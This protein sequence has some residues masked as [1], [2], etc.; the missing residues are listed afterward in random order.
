MFTKIEISHRTIIFTIALLGAIWLILQILDILYFMFIAF[1]IMSTLRPLVDWLSMRRIPRLL[2]ILIIYCVI[3]GFVGVSLLGTVPALVVQS[4]R[5]MQNLPAFTARIFPYWTIDMNAISQQIAP[6]GEN[7]VKVT[8]GIFSNI[9]TTFAVLI[10]SFYFLLEYKQSEKYLG[11][12][13][14]SHRAAD[15]MA[16]IRR[17]EMRLGA[18]VQGE[19]LLMVFIGL[20]TYIGLLVL[21]IEFALPL[22]IFAGFL[23][24]IPMIGPIISAIPAII[25][26]LA[27]SPIL[28]L[29]IIALY[30]IVQQVENN[31]VVP[32]VM[33]RSVGLSPLITII[34]LMIGGR[35]AGVT[36]AVLA[37]PVVLVLQELLCAFL[38]REQKQK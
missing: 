25:V 30:F 35:L 29:S 6:I 24:I 27:T 32:L 10:F 18:W 19:L 21:K 11:S 33:K 28:A 8:V 31:L 12:F 15:V 2:S 23:E 37:V 34:T 16:V 5:L 1:I 13:I 9:L 3:F 7:I 14:G 26:A 22:A 20:L 4:T 36:G 38:N 17:I